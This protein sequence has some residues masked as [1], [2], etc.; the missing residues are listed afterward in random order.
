MAKETA[1]PTESPFRVIPAVDVL[2][3]EAVRLAQGE[4]G[5][6]AMRGGDPAELVGRFAAAGATLVHVVDL[7]GAR[8]GRLRLELFSTLAAA[9]GSTPIQAS[10]GIRSLAD[11]QALL[12]A[13]A[14]RVVVGTAAFDSADAL[15]RFAELG[16]RL[17]I[18][19]DSR[20]G[21]VAVA[22]WRRSTGIAVEEAA[23]ACAGAGIARILCT[24]IDR[25]GTLRGPDLTLLERVRTAADGVPVLAAGG[26][27]VQEDLDALERL[28]LEGA[29][30]GRALLDGSLQLGGAS[31]S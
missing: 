29:I 6:I 5:R 15:E 10:G 18:A 22:G 30:V 7:D 23:A 4:F 25:D 13:G 16:E 28:G 19:V 1:G 12:D 26:I 20:D 9:A 21:V 14:A 8:R 2:D 27:R 11:A 31:C 3:G 24:A 17:V